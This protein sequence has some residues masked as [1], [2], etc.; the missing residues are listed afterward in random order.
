MRPDLFIDA[1]VSGHITKPPNDRYRG[2]IDWLSEEG[3]L[4]VCRSLLN[5]Y[6]DAVRGSSLWT[7]PAIVDR[8]TRA[9]RLV[10]FGKRDI[11]SFRIKERLLKKLL[12]NRSDHDYIKIVMMSDRNLALSR[13]NALRRDINDFPRYKARAYKDPGDFDYRGVTR[14]GS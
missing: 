7:L 14:A 11:R 10:R 9:G 8:L 2:L 4:V 6:V 3:Y 12:S 13:D 5:E 1:N